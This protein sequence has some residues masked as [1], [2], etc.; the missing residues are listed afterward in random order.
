MRIQS[1]LN[2]SWLKTIWKWTIDTTPVNNV[3]NYILMSTWRFVLFKNGT[4]DIWRHNNYLI[5]FENR[6]D[7]F[8]FKLGICFVV[9]TLVLYA[10]SLEAKQ[11]KGK[12]F[13]YGTLVETSRLIMI[14]VY[15]LNIGWRE[16]EGVFQKLITTFRS[17]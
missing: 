6:T 11:R 12:S 14:V 3:V 10:R 9:L 17:S 7:F 15:R 13:V 4:A 2:Q 8:I 1:V 5:I 16:Y